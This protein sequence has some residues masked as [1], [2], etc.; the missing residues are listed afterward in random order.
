MYFFH[1]NRIDITLQCVYYNITMLYCV[2]NDVLGSQDNSSGVNFL[3]QNFPQL[4]A[5]GQSRLKDYLKSLVSLQNTMIGTET[6]DS[7]RDSVKK[8]RN[9]N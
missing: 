4:S 8:N 9:G 7:V 1:I 2:E 3:E 5:E 6:A